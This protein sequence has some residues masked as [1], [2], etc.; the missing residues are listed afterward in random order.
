[1]NSTLKEGNMG[2]QLAPKTTVSKVLDL[3]AEVSPGSTDRLR[4]LLEQE[5]EVPYDLIDN[6]DDLAGAYHF[7]LCGWGRVSHA[8]YAQIVEWG[9]EG[10]CG[11]VTNTERVRVLLQKQGVHLPA[12]VCIDALEGLYW[13]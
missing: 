10:A 7:H 3:L 1:M 9:Y 5:E 8:V 2:I 12:G 4:R 13:C 11:V 6:D